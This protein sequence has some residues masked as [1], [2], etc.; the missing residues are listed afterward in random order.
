MSAT[1][2][3]SDRTSSGQ[4]VNAKMH[5]MNDIRTRFS[6]LRNRSQLL[7]KDT[8]IPSRSSSES[9]DSEEA[10]I[11]LRINDS[12]DDQGM[13]GDGFYEPYEGNVVQIEASHLH[14]RRRKELLITAVSH[15]SKKQTPPL[16]NRTRNTTRP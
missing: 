12:M 10:A 6:D 5:D 15:V 16:I 4:F 1:Y 9:I 14:S 2:E 8:D 7:P 13:S 3:R 11:K